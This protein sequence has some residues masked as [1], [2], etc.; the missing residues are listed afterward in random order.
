MAALKRRDCSFPIK[1]RCSRRTTFG[2]PLLVRVCCAARS[3]QSTRF[4]ASQKPRHS[5]YSPRTRRHWRQSPKCRSSID[6]EQIDERIAI[7]EAE[8]GLTAERRG[9]GNE[10]GTIANVVQSS[11]HFGRRQNLSTH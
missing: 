4:S 5:R 9:E 2:R 11:L 7:S 1:P 3:S 8:D 10:G 6:A